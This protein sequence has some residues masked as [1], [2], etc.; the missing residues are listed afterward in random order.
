MEGGAALRQAI[1][2]A[3]AIARYRELVEEFLRA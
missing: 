3:A 2:H 1:V